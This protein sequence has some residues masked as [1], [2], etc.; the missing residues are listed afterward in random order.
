MDYSL[1][2]PLVLSASGVIEANGGSSLNAAA[3]ANPHGLAME[4]CEIRWRLAPKS[5]TQNDQFQATGQSIAMKLDLGQ[6]AIVG[7]QVPVGLFGSFRDSSEFAAE[8]YGLDL[9]SPTVTVQPTSYFWRPEYPIFVPANQILTPSF[10]HM[11]QIGLPYQL[12]LVYIGRTLPPDYK[13]GSIMLPWISAWNFQSF[14]QISGGLGG[15]GI[16]SELTLNNPFGVP[17]K[18]SKLT[19]RCSLINASNPGATTFTNYATEE[20]F[21]FRQRLSALRIRSSKGEDVVRTQTPFDGLFPYGWREWDIEGQWIMRPGEFYKARLDVGNV[22]FT[23]DQAFN[24]RVQFSVG[25]VG[26]RKVPVAALD[27]PSIAP[28][29]AATAAVVVQPAGSTT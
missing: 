9:Q 25:L 12:D 19:G 17:M 22:D 23:V 27:D 18:I 10:E 21:Q 3:L 8:I 24:G 11:G 15:T 20:L 16:S 28:A 26:C 6:A 7:E 4:V 2:D 1:S 5:P 29:S 13:P 14:Q